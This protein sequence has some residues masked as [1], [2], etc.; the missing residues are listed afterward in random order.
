[1]KRTAPASGFLAYK[2]RPSSPNANSLRQHMSNL[3][4][5]HLNTGSTPEKVTP[6]TQRP[7]RYKLSNC[8]TK[9]GHILVEFHLKIFI[10]RINFLINS[11]VKSTFIFYRS[12]KKI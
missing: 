12:D 8:F 6:P 5:S 9:A 1:M 11:G 3:A 7:E 2:H 10:L 4:L